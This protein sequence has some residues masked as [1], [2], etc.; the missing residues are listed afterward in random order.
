MYNLIE[1]GGKMIENFIFNDEVD[2]G[3][4]ILLVDY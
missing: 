1:S 2:I 4:I 3:V